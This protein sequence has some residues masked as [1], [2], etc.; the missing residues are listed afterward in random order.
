MTSKNNLSIQDFTDL[1]PP[2]EKYPAHR[3]KT[4]E[5]KARGKTRKGA[6]HQVVAAAGP[7]QGKI[8]PAEY[9]RRTKRQRI[10]KPGR[11]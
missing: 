9:R 4:N 10:S 6:I 1:F 3:N 2:A 7:S 5:R 8:T 11:I